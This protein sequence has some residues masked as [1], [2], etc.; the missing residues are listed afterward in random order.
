M[1]DI[2][3]SLVAEHGAW[4]KKDYRSEWRQQKNITR[5]WKK[6][7]EPILK[8]NMSC[9][10]RSFIEDKE[11]GIA[12]HYRKANPELAKIKASELFDYLNEF[13]ANT[14]LQ[15]MHGN[16]V[17][18]VRIGGVNKGEASKFFLG[19]KR[20]DFILAMGDDWT[21]EDMFKILPSKAYSIRIGYKPTQAKFYLESPRECRNLL[22]QLTK[23]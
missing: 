13:L 9:V 5:Q 12:W 23:K 7:V 17:I 8:M 16:K 21:D 19:L 4:I 1:G 10:P 2:P 18:E 14:D 6:Q 15:V 3:C 20:W 11:Y 22:R